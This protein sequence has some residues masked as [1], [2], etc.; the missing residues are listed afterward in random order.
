MRLLRKLPSGWMFPV[1]EVWASFKHDANFSWYLN[2][3]AKQTCWKVWNIPFFKWKTTKKRA[4]HSH[5]F[6]NKH[7]SHKLKQIAAAITSNHNCRRLSS[8]V[9]CIPYGTMES[10]VYSNRWTTLGRWRALYSLIMSNLSLVSHQSTRFVCYEWWSS[11]QHVI[12]ART[13]CSL[14]AASNKS[15]WGGSWDIP[16]VDICGREVVARS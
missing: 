10:M 4:S 1:H 3:C 13:K 8:Y 11:S 5:S 9:M 7:A 6:L 16:T 2:R 14:I 12:A 15:Y